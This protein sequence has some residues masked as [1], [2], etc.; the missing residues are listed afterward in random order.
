VSAA[1]RPLR[2]KE[3]GV[4]YVLLIYGDE[5]VHESIGDED[6]A[7][8]YEEYGKFAAWLEEKGWMRGG[9][10]LAS[11]KTATT[12]RVRD[13]QVLSTDGPFTETKEQLG[14]YFLIDCDDLDQAIEAASRIPAVH[15]GSIEV[16]PIVDQEPA[17]HPH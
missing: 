6:R 10:E 14:G 1:D 2:R 5:S 7:Q 13:G 17:D 8:M 3:I 9:D 16:R 12:V 4:R 11:V 15:G